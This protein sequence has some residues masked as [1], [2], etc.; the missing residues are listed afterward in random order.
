MYLWD[1]TPPSPTPPA[2]ILRDLILRIAI[3]GV[4]TDRFATIRRVC[5]PDRRH[6]HIRSDYVPLGEFANQ[7][8]GTEARS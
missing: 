1:T 2:G 6:M 7:V 5:T 3:V 8:W 4:L